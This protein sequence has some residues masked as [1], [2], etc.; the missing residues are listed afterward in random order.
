MNP[1][2]T[3][4]KQSRGVH[5][6]PAS[7]ALRLCFI[8]REIDTYRR[9]ADLHVDKEGQFSNYHLPSQS[10]HKTVKSFQVSGL[11]TVLSYK[12]PGSSVGET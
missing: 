2:M 9:M 1:A 11:Y 8:K 4:Q 5:L 7:V 3:S 10:F 12:W 6:L